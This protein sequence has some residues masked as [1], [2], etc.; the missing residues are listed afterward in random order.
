MEDRKEPESI[1][2]DS[3]ARLS[4][5]SVS[6]RFRDINDRLAPVDSI[7]TELRYVAYP[8]SYTHLTLPTKRIV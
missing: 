6:G 1:E 4:D 5:F 8:V 3:M 7:I 2:S